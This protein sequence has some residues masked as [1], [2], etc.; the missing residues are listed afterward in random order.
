[1]VRKDKSLAFSAPERAEPDDED[2]TPTYR[3][4]ES[5][6]ILGKLFR[7]IDEHEIFADVQQSKTRKAGNAVLSGI[8][9][10]IERNC[11]IH[12]VKSYYMGRARGIREE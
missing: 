8:L 3:Y 12:L 5:D 11:A 9:K 1:M 2:D 4:Y 7:A 6:K 10:Y